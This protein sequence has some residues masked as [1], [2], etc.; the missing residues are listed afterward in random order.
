MLPYERRVLALFADALDPLAELRRFG[1]TASVAW[2]SD[3]DVDA[4][5]TG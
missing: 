1:I 4:L 5:V 3:Q 2:H